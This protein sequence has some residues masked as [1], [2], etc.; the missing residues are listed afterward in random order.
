MSNY[1]LDTTVGTFWI[2]TDHDYGCVRL[3]MGGD[4]LGVYPDPNAAA[5]QVASHCSGWDA[6]DLRRPSPS[7]PAGLADWIKA[8]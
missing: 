8:R 2:R 5:A 1:F 7:D 4:D 3:G 6:W